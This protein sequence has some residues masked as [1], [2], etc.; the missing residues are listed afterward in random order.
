[1]LTTAEPCENLDYSRQICMEMVAWDHKS[2]YF[3]Y[4]SIK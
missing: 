1:M 3:T 4:T 2:E